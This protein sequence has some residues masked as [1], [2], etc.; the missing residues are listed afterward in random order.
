MIIMIVK[1][2]AENPRNG[3]RPPSDSTFSVKI[4]LLSKELLMLKIPEISSRDRVEKNNIRGIE[5]TQ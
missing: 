5:I 3:G 4:S 2:L 1:I